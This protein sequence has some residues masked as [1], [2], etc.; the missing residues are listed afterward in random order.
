MGR[1]ERQKRQLIEESNKRLLCEEEELD[2]KSIYKDVEKLKEPGS[3]MPVAGRHGDELTSD[4]KIEKIMGDVD[5]LK[6]PYDDHSGHGDEETI[7]DEVEY[8]KD[9][10]TSLVEKLK[11]YER[12][13]DDIKENVDNV[14]KFFDERQPNNT[15][16]YEE[17]ISSLEEKINNLT[18]TPPEL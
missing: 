13:N 5:L 12:I 17:R 11:N 18:D 1:I 8:L 3:D 14:M 15:F 9:V 10:V 16:E 2:I 4:E 7:E 6:Y